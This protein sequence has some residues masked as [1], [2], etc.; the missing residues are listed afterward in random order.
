MVS[1]KEIQ[2]GPYRLGPHHPPMIVAELSG[3]HNRSLTTALA[4]VEKAKEAGAHAVKLQTYTPDTIT[5]DVKEGDFLI[6]DPES[7][8]KGRNL[9]DLYREAHL[10]W[11]WHAPLFERC[12]ELGLVCFSSPFDETAVDFLETLDVP[13]YKIASP[14][15]VDHALIRRAAQTGK[16]LI[17]STAAA[18]LVEI[19]EAVAAARGAGCKEIILLKCTAAYPAQPK[20]ANLRTLP[21]LA[22][23]FDTLVGLS[24][25]SLG[26]GV[27][28]ASVALGACFIEKH[29]TLSRDDGG[30]DSAFSMEPQEF[31][32]LVEE[33]LRAWEALGHIRYAPLHAERVTQSHRPSLF[34]VENLPVG[35]IIQ[36]HHLRTVR[37]G[38][39][40]PPKEL[41]QLLGL[42][43]KRA[44][45]KGTPA[46][47]DLFKEP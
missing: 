34:F 39:G 12:K 40:L 29:L 46:A 6:T 2:I 13:C 4:L 33:S 47:W 24:D 15:I 31:Q 3:N 1:I 21:H 17:L 5:L 37:P 25:H 26:I 42:T 16:P 7:L 23:C 43:L 9:Y 41:K 22:H 14:E 19:G 10:P 44:V 20:D 8:W 32:S 27:A 30:V 38:T 35:T 11:E 36:S 18:T 28:V 45:K